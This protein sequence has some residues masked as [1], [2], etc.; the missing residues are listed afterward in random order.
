MKPTQPA[1]PAMTLGNMRGLGVQWLIAS[2]LH[3]FSPRG[4]RVALTQAQRVR[5]QASFRGG[6]MPLALNEQK[7]L[8]QFLRLLRRALSP[9]P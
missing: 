9:E 1:G 5:S 6:D 2:C 7:L 3:G 4:W 8:R